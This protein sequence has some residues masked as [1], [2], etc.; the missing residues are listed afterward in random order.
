MIRY[1]NEAERSLGFPQFYGA[2][3]ERN[4]NL[5]RQV[6][7]MSTRNKKAGRSWQKQPAGYPFRD[8]AVQKANDQYIYGERA[9]P[10]QFCAELCQFCARPFGKQNI[11]FSLHFD[12]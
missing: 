11:L 9:E 3:N 6:E 10:C 2:R 7:K 4:K 8:T 1:P 12:V 5:E